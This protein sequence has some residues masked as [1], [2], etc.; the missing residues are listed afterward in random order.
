MARTIITVLKEQMSRHFGLRNVRFVEVG[1][2]SLIFE[3]KVTKDFVDYAARQEL[4][5]KYEKVDADARRDAAERRLARNL[6]EF[7]DCFVQVLIYP[8]RKV[9]VFFPTR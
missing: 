6:K 5:E 8:D 2:D 1:T 3:A 7:S 4:A 9:K